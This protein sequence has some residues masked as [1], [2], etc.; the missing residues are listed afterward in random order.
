MGRVLVYL[1]PRFVSFLIGKV[2]TIIVSVGGTVISIAM[3][4][5][6]FAFLALGILVTDV[7]LDLW[8]MKPDL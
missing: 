5:L 4:Y 7:L 2:G 8:L 6:L 1:L 3:Q